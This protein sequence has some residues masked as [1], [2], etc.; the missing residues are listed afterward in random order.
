MLAEAKKEQD[1][2]LQKVKKVVYP[3]WTIAFM[4]HSVLLVGY[5]YQDKAIK[6]G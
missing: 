2:S 5:Y 3:F 4:I 6:R 1:E